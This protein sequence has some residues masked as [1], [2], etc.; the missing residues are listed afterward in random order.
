MSS[1]NIYPKPC[2]Y[3]CNTQIYWNSSE[4]TYFE[5]FSQKKH[6][7]PNRVNNK[8]ATVNTTNSVE[9]TTTTI[10]NQ[11]I[12][13]KNPGIHNYNQRCPTHLNY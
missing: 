7:C 1:Q 2:N 10:L 13:T 12:V 9:S 4:N 3:G 6:S 8:P 5:V 11:L